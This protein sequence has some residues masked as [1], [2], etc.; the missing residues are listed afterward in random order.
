MAKPKTKRP[1]S[2]LP[3]RDEVLAF[4]NDHPGKAGKREI[5]RAFGITGADRIQL[6]Q[7]LK[8]LAGE[9]LI[10][11]RNKRLAT[12]GA[13]P[14]VGVVTI[15]DRTSDGDL[16]ATPANWDEA[17]GDA[18]RIV[19]L[20]GR[21]RVPAPGV[22]DRV[23]A[24]L[25]AAGDGYTAKIIRV[26][27]RQPETTLG[28]VR[29]VGKEFRLEPVDRKQ[30]EAMIPSG[31]LGGAEEGDLVSVKIGRSRRGQ[32]AEAS[33]VKTMG[34]MQ[35]EKAV[36]MIAILAHG[37]PFEFPEAALAEAKAAQPVRPSKDREDWRHL[38]LITIDPPDA[39]DHDDAVHAAPDDDAK[40]KGGFVVIV[41]IA[42]VGWF[43]RPDTA[44][45]REA[46]KRGNSVYFPDRVVPMLPE[47][48]SGD[49]CSLR[50]GKDRPALAVRLVF[51]ADGRKRSHSF[52]RVL[53]RSVANLSYT[54]AQAAFDRGDDPP[55]EEVG[56]P[57]LK[58]LWA[59]YQAVAKARAEREPLELVIP[60]RKVIIGRGRQDRTHHP[61]RDTRH[62]PPDRG[63]HDPGECRRSGNAGEGQVPLGLS[64]P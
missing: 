36:S 1:R 12:P 64:H 11:K 22:G 29:R 25:T 33:V 54:D 37:I 31:A 10:A 30:R 4:I 49:L 58:P 51:G 6:K 3:S 8:E 63:V 9:G 13:M 42:D 21:G 44:L 15:V 17:T 62:P 28:V 2:A 55:G 18:P 24:R 38:P 48:L 26:L 60:E 50:V 43:V 5:A 41:A 27:E 19:V 53:I 45:D 35:D 57:I 56:A 47:R 16:V 61:A 20:T 52:H 40:N 23:L 46:R 14:P 34:S 59:A 7:M 39:K 32:L